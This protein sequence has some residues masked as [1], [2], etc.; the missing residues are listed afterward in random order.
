L[1]LAEIS[2]QETKNKIIK[3]SLKNPVFPSLDSILK[4]DYIIENDI[5]RKVNKHVNSTN[6]ISSLKSILNKE[7]SPKKFKEDLNGLFSKKNKSKFDKNN[8]SGFNNDVNELST[9][10]NSRYLSSP[11]EEKITTHIKNNS[12]DLTIENTV[13]EHFPV[14]RSSLFRNKNRSR[15]AFVSEEEAFEN[16]CIPEKINEIINKKTSTYYFLKNIDLHRED[17]ENY[18]LKNFD[19]KEWIEFII[20]IK[21]YNQNK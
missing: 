1:E 14:K 17:Y 6:N 5:N 21:K 18:I 20:S 8:L 7:K 4:K 9:N 15:F 2:S 10:S 11:N 16:V 3:T 13:H 12:A 19:D